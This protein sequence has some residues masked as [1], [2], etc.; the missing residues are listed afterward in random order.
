MNTGVNGYNED[1]INFIVIQR[2]F[3]KMSK[4]TELL[5]VKVKADTKDR[6]NEI[7]EKAKSAGMI[8]FNG[9]IFDLFIER[10]QHDEL[11]TKMEYGADLKE[12]NQITRRINDIFINL[13]E[14]NETNLDDLKSQH[15]KNTLALHEEIQGLKEK[16]KETQDLLTEKGNKIKEL[17]KLV[18]VNQERIKE[19]EGLQNSQ[20]ER[21]E[22]QKSIIDEKNEKIATKNEIISQKEEDIS[23]MKEDIAQL[24]E[25]KKKAQQTNNTLVQLQKHIEEKNLELKRQKENLEFECQKRV[26]AREQELNKEKATEIKNIQDRLTKELSRSQEK[27]EKLLGEKDKLMNANYELQISLDREQSDNER[28]ESIIASKEKENEEL[29]K[30]I[31][32]L[33]SASKK[34]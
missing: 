19:L 7:I 34:K 28:K 3:L 6:I 12:L 16:K 18:E 29:K 5:G 22:E 10:F 25:L 15:E 2:R 4:N 8:E 20:M 27:Y 32:Q 1:I 26:F 17:T 9:D 14:R 13:A 30:K 33:E 24:D 21:I 11:A 23:A 31:Q